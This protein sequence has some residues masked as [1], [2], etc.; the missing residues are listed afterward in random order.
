LHDLM[1]HALR[2]SREINS[3]LASFLTRY[4][5]AQLPAP[6]VRALNEHEVAVALAGSSSLQRNP[7]TR[8]AWVEQDGMAL[9]FAAGDE[10]VC[11]IEIAQQ[12]CANPVQLPGNVPFDEATLSFLCR[13]INDGHLFF[14]HSGDAVTGETVL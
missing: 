2:S 14:A 9:L 4:R 1:D 8:M 13:L 3:F 12:L 6:P 11:G 10:Y 7:W 5:L